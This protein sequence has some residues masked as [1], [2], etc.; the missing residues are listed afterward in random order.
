MIVRA[1]P[2][3]DFHWI[4]TRASLSLGTMATAIEAIDET[5]RIHG[6]VAYDNWTPN[7][8]MIHL[9]LDSRMAARYLL[10]PA[11]AYPFIDLNREILIGIVRE[12]NEKALKLD[13]HLGFEVAH[14]IRN[15]WD[16]GENLIVLEMRRD[17]CRWLRRKAA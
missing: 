5:G 15:G 6:M 2:R 7:S 12:S 13:F 11:F 1:A 16:Q 8:A 17:N 14:T 3:P 4:E 10:G 9:A